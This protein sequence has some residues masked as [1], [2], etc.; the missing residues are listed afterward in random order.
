[1][2]DFFS[3]LFLFHLFLSNMACPRRMKRKPTDGREEPLVTPEIVNFMR[4]E[5]TIH[6]IAP[7]SS[8]ILSYYASPRPCFV[9]TLR[10][11]K[12]YP[13]DEMEL[14][15][16]AS[17]EDLRRAAAEHWKQ[18][19]SLLHEAEDDDVDDDQDSFPRDAPDPNFL[20]SPASW[21]PRLLALSEAVEDKEHAATQWI[22]V[23]WGISLS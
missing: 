20:D 3:S 14:H 5:L 1:M 7:L 17:L 18:S 11:V 2:H 13:H 19:K 12:Y 22:S 9:L 4:F 21:L 10:N 23:V 16:F 15:E 8:I 6:L